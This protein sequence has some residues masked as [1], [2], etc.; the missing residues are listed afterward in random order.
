MNLLDIIG[1]DCKKIILN[2][3]KTFDLI[4]YQKKAIIDLINS[5]ICYCE[6]NQRI[7]GLNIYYEDFKDIYLKH[8]RLNKKIKFQINCYGNGH[9]N[10]KKIWDL[11]LKTDND[12]MLY[13]YRVITISKNI[14]EKSILIQLYNRKYDYALLDKQNRRTC[15]HSLFHNL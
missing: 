3:K 1:P 9:S 13:E 10:N 15:G 5:S 4:I 6:K 14:T 12:E 7:K 2:Y 11:D 8:N